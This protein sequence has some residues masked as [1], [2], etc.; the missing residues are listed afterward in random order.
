MGSELRQTGMGDDTKGL[1]F[2]KA[3]TQYARE[4]RHNR[5]AQCVTTLGY[6]TE[7][8]INVLVVHKALLHK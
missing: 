3:K 6:I 1:V 5:C 2:L 8:E 7:R 4:A